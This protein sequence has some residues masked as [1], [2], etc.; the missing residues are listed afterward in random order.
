MFS[1][2]EGS[3]KEL[4]ALRLASRLLCEM[5]AAGVKTRVK[6]LFGEED[7]RA[8][9]EG[10][11][12]MGGTLCPACAKVQSLEH[13]DLHLVYPVPSGDQ[14]KELMLVI[15]SRR[16]DFFSFGE[17]GTRSR[18][19]GIDSVRR[20]IEILGKRPF[21]GRRSVVL[22][23]EAHRATIEAQN[24]LL[25]ILEE[26]PSSAV[27]VL[28]TEF[29]DRLLPTVVSRCREERFAPMASETIAE[30]LERFRSVEKMEA[31][32]IATMAQ[33]N[34]KRALRFLEERYISLWKDASTVLGLVVDSKGAALLAESERIAH[35]YSREEI[36]EFLEELS[37]LFSMLARE[38]AG[39]SSESSGS[40]L[41]Q[42]L[43]IERASRASG[44]DAYE[45]IRKI[46]SAKESLAR[47]ADPELTLAHLF[48]DLAG[49]WY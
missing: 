24:A 43:G 49:K 40:L 16:E 14:E 2:P 17:F 15:G 1:G 19:I 28:V 31:W 37:L 21:E 3:G 9:I 4:S 13:P 29:P 23:F 42:A 45:D 46:T 5:G 39:C 10:R 27:L 6:G 25:K 26:P 12:G 33:G 22:F 7:T 20:V 11:C 44:R 48:L 35:R 36:G 18:S 34:L 32:R 38:K 41:E 47:N 30:I 8:S